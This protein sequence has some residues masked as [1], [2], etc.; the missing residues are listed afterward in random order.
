[1]KRGAVHSRSARAMRSPVHTSAPTV[2]IRSIC[3]LL[4][5][6]RSIREP[7]PP[8]PF[9]LS[10]GTVWRKGRQGGMRGSRREVAS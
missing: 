10:D 9:F 6:L 4:P 7:A 2:R 3:S 5:L 1:M 8:L